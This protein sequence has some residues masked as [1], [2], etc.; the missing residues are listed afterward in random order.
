MRARRLMVLLALAALVAA[1]CGGSD[2]GGGDDTGSATT[3]GGGDTTTGDDGGGGGGGD[4]DGTERIVMTITGGADAGDYEIVAPDAGCSFGLA[5]EGAWGN[6]YSQ[7]GLGDGGFS[8]LQLV[9]N[10]AEAAA[11]GTEN[12]FMTVEIG[13]L[14]AGTSYTVD[15]GEGDGTGTVTVDDRGGDDATVTIDAETAD[16]VHI[17]ATIECFQVIRA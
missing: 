7:T 11:S 12:F 9:V 16:G 8:S 3:T 15:P 10:D 17:E 2:D 1:G 4:G 6:Q 13:E 14:F 5:S